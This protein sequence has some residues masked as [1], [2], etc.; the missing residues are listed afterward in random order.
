MLSKILKIN[1]VSG[2]FLYSRFLYVRPV[3]AVRHTDDFNQK[4]YY[5]KFG[6]KSEK[7]PLFTK[8]WYTLLILGFTLPL[9]NYDWYEILL[10][11]TD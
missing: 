11:V 2:R 8:I 10:F 9:V 6:H 3:L 4:R 5:K 7:E 1:L